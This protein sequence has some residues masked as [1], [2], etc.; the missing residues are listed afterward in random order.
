MR[1]FGTNSKRSLRR[2]FERTKRKNTYDTWHCFSSTKYWPARR[3]DNGIARFKRDDS[4]SPEHVAQFVFGAREGSFP[5]F[6]QI[7]A[8]AIDIEIQHRHRGLIRLR[9]SPLAA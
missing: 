9:L 2:K 7:F 1:Q 4:I 8:S 5:A 3:A 6:G